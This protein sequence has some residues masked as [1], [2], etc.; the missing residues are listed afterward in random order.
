MPLVPAAVPP[1][2]AGPLALAALTCLP[3]L[4]VVRAPFAVVPALSLAFWALSFWWPPLAGGSRG[5]FV[6]AGL[7][8]SAV[9][10]SLRL[11]PKHEVSPPPGFEPPPAAP[12]SSRRGLPPP[13]LAGAASLGVLAAA[14]LLLVPLPLW[15]HAPGPSLAFATTMTRLVLWRDGVPLSAEPLLPLAPFGAHSPPLPTL[16]SDVARLSGLDPGRAVLLVLVV[17]VGLVLLGLYAVLAT[18]V[19]PGA[20]ALGALVGLALVP[21][22]DAL[23]PWGAGEAVVALAFLLPAAA[24]LLG[25]RS[26]SSAVAAGLLLGA[27]LLAQPLLSLLATAAVA[28]AAAWSG[29]RQK[30]SPGARRVLG[31]ALLGWLLASPGLLPLARAL[32]PREALAVF[33]AVSPRDAWDVILGVVCLILGA[34]AGRRLRRAMGG[35][36]VVFPGLLSAVA[37][38]LRVHVW[39]GAGQIDPAT[40]AALAGASATPS[41]EALCG[42]ERVRDWIPALAGRPAGEPG[43]YIPPVY[44]EEWAAHPVRPCTPLAPP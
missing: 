11:L 36:L 5:A 14:L 16:A 2:L 34:L 28:A 19:P 41:L 39:I 35:R 21:W 43:P 4:L 3:G 31:A 10:A 8:G 42:D 44:R 22:P 38:V 15:N 17:S 30:P 23:R 29:T 24:L 7:V 33:A 26:R 37:L 40:R 13:R 6:W 25:H 9:I 27:G 32:S 20:A 12:P 18:R 1:T